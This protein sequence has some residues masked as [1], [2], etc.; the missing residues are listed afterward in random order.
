MSTPPLEA[1]WSAVDGYSVRP[2]AYLSSA[3]RIKDFR[4]IV[5]GRQECPLEEL[6]AAVEQA[7]T[8]FAAA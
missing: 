1:G 5:M 6:I 2:L 7:R 4:P 3:R 8:A